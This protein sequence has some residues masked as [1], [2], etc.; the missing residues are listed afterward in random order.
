MTVNPY[1]GVVDDGE[2]N[3]ILEIV[4]AVE[5]DVCHESAVGRNF[6]VRVDRSPG[7]RT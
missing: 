5:V 2:A 3:C 1:G 7:E 4:D 6:T